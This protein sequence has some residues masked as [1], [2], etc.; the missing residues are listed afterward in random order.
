[1]YIMYDTKLKVN[2]GFGFTQE[3]NQSLQSCGCLIH[4]P[5]FFLH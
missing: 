2:S 4:Q 3:R 5:D 1:M